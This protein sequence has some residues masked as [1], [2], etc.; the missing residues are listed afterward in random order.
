MTP[1]QEALDAVRPVVSAL[2]RLGVP[3]YIGGSVAATAFGISRTTNDIDLIAD[4]HAEHAAPLCQLLGSDYYADEQSIRTAAQRHDSFNVIYLPTM[5]KVDVFLLKPRGFDRVSMERR[6]PAR[7]VAD[8]PSTAF[9][10]ATPEDVILNKL[11][12]FRLGGEV[13]ERQWLDLMTVM[14]VQA[15]TLD[16]AYLDRWAAEIGVSDLLARARREAAPY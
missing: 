2:E 13:S 6:R 7:V 15:R 11:E 16:H 9:P 4:L 3:Y 12:W 10:L 1:N 5:F 14:N 8:D